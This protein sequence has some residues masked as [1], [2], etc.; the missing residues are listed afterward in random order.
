MRSDYEQRFLQIERM[1]MSERD[2]YKQNLD[3]LKNENLLI[4]THLTSQQPTQP[5]NEEVVL[6]LNDLRNAIAVAQDTYTRS[7]SRQIK[8]RTLDKIESIVQIIE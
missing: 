1:L 5:P 4:R 6:L 7:Y 3:S 8:G 2:R